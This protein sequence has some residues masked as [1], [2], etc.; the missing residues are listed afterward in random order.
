MLKAKALLAAEADD[1]QA[2]PTGTARQIQ[3]APESAASSGVEKFVVRKQNMIIE[4]YGEQDTVK[5]WIT[6]LAA[7]LVARD[8]LIRDLILRLRQQY[9]ARQKEFSFSLA[10]WNEEEQQV[11]RSLFKDELCGIV[12]SVE[13]EANSS[14]ISGNLVFS[15]EAQTF[16]TGQYME[17]GVYEMIRQALDELPAAQDISCHLYRNVRVADTEGRIRNE[18]DIVIERNGI[19]YVVE[20]KSCKQFNAWGSLLEVGRE[21]GI[22][23]DRLLLVDSYLTDEQAHRIESFCRYYV[24]NLKSGSLQQKVIGMVSKDLPERIMDQ[25]ERENE[26]V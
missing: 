13:A 15:P 16:L 8:E 20:V 14:R 5:E 11:I 26:S 21:Y 18:F 23:P 19:F 2:G 24:T 7:K 25:D 12:D 4:S 10:A 3:A 17:I 22:V 1:R 9:I 6:R